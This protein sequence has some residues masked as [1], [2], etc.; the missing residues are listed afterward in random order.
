MP[1]KVVD[2]SIIAAV[3]FGESRAAEAEV[4]LSDSALSSPPLMAYELA[5]VARK[6]PCST[7]V[8]LTP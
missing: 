8:R 2:A 6:K 4:L 7:R 3:A 1:A 5:S